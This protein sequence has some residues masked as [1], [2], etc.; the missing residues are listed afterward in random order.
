MVWGFAREGTVVTT[1]FGSQNFISKADKK[2]VWRTKLPPTPASLVPH[3]ISFAASTGET[4]SLSDVLFGDVYVCG[5]QSNMRFEVKHN[6]NSTFY[7]EQANKYPNIRIF[8]AGDG[9]AKVP[10]SLHHSC[11]SPYSQR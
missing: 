7:A 8:T 1:T 4:A 3:T 11:S 10:P 6:T 9:V 5:G 2:S